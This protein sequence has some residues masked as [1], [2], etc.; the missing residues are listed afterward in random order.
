MRLFSSLNH[1]ELPRWRGPLIS[2]VLKVFDPAWVVTPAQ[3]VEVWGFHPRRVEVPYTMETIR[4]CAAQNRLA[5]EPQEWR[6]AYLFDFS[7]REMYELLNDG[8][9]R[10][11]FDPDL[12]WLARERVQRTWAD[13]T[14]E[15]RC[16]LINICGNYENR[17]WFDQEQELRVRARPS[18]V[19][20]PSPAI[21]QT[22]FDINFLHNKRLLVDWCHAGPERD[23]TGCH[24]CV[25]PFGDRG[26]KISSADPTSKDPR[27]AVCYMIP[28][29]F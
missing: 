13:D 17:S 27:R 1:F 2:D 15:A 14:I 28:P 21:A 6:L 8:S 3:A 9:L 23:S 24:I 29:E 5:I 25:G 19:R 16:R 26:L 20:T 18:I 22:I 10:M 12:Q 11:H 4:W 7:L